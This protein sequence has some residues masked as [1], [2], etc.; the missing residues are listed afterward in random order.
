MSDRDRIPELPPMAF[1]EAA[2]EERLERVWKRLEG[3]LG[4]A[5]TPGLVRSRFRRRRDVI[6]LAPAAVVVFASGVLVDQAFRPVAAPD[7]V[8][9][10]EPGVTRTEPAATPEPAPEP[11]SESPDSTER[12]R[13]RRPRARSPRVAVREPPSDE[14]EVVVVESAEPAP[15]SVPPEWYRLWDEDEYQKARET[16]ERQ[17]GFEAAL[18]QASADQAMA[19]VD[20]A[21]FSRENALAIAALRRVVDRYPSDPNAPIAALTLGN[22]LE[23]AGDTQG[24]AEAFQSYRALSPEGDFAEDALARQIEVA[25]E[26]R[27]HVRAGEL[28]TQY[29]QE[30]PNGTRLEEL[31][32]ELR[33]AEAAAPVEPV[34]APASQSSDES[35]ASYEPPIRIPVKGD[36]P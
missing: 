13:E 28:L 32:A 31:R 15:Q 29:E 17:G 21:R 1:A 7:V 9:G 4:A 12:V 16:I 26:R 2:T 18:E 24:A 14:P 22:M 19:L 5:E 11:R 27:D 33:E 36:V 8:L 20:L 10:R 35:N 25:I 6:L 30:F 34:P 23:R 3:D